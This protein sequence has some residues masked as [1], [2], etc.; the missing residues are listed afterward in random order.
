MKPGLALLL[1]VSASAAGAGSPDVL[2]KVDAL[3][4]AKA[5]RPA[6]VAK[7]LGLPLKFEEEPE[8]ENEHFTTHVAE[9]APESGFGRIELRASR[10]DPRKG[11]LIL[12][13]SPRAVVTLDEVF[14]RYGE[15]D[16]IDVPHPP[17]TWGK[18]VSGVKLPVSYVYRRGGVELS[19]VES[20]STA[21]RAASVTLDSIP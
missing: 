19:V 2:A 5:F 17:H 21:G 8:S 15:A 20:T 3:A 10:T 9:A 11:L 4:K 6:R 14:R 7:T 12:E 16:G 1:A 18:G 13:L